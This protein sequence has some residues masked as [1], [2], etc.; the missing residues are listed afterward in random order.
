MMGGSF[1]PAYILD[2]TAIPSEVQPVTNKRNAYLV[3]CFMAEVLH[4]PSNRGVVRFT[5][6]EEE[7]IATNGSTVAGEIERA[8]KDAAPTSGK[9]EKSNGLVRSLTSKSSRKSILSEKRKSVVA[10][11]RKSIFRSPDKREEGGDSTSIYHTIERKFSTRSLRSVK[12]FKGKI[13]APVPTEFPADLLPSPTSISGFSIASSKQ[14]PNLPKIH[15]LSP[16]HGLSN[17]VSKDGTFTKDLPPPSPLSQ[18]PPSI[19]LP[20]F[21][22]S[23]DR[24]GS[25]RD[26]LV[27]SSSKRPSLGARP[28]S[29]RKNL[30]NITGPA[31]AIPSPPPIPMDEPPMS[32]RLS[33]R[34]S[35]V[36]LFKKGDGGIRV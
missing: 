30:S 16:L 6:L 14:L 13:S 25:E 9:E 27:T 20:S 5:A 26:Q 15:R 35:F 36:A 33:K 34:K 7:K 4:V 21:A 23:S 24:T 8:E 32:P 31:D 12:S 17:S 2:V 28:Q 11:N 18:N 1:E 10:D 29:S 3:Q 19:P 22:P